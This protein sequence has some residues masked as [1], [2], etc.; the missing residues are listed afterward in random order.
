MATS[1]TGLR[2][3]DTY[4]AI[5]KIGDNSN[6]S[7]T[8]KLLSDGVGNDT[9]LYLSGTRLGIGITPA[10]QFHTSGNAKIGGNLIISGNLT[11]NGTLTYLNVTDLQVEDP[12]IKLAK[13]N[14]SNTLDIGF[15][16]KYVESATTKY[17]GLFWDASTDK[18]RLYEGLQVEPTTT[19]DVTG[20]GYT[21]SLLNA[22][23]EGN[24]TGTVSS[25]SNHDTND[26]VEGSVNLYFT[27]AR[28]RASFT[29]GTGVTI[30]NG[31][32]AIGQ[33]VGTTSNV[34]FGN[35]TGSAISGTTGTFSGNINIEST[36][37]RINLTDT[38]NND[39][40]SIFNNNGTYTVFN[41]TDAVSAFY[42][43]SSNNA[44][45]AGNVDINGNLQ[46][47]G[48][49][50][51]SSGDAGTSG[52]LLSST[53]TGTNWIDFE[54]DVAKRIDVTV[55]NVSGASLAKGVVVHAA[56]TATPPSGNV[57]EVIAADANVASSMPAIGILNETIA[58]EAE[59][60]AVM[61][62]AVSG[63]DTSGFSIGDE[64]YVSETVGL[65]T[66]TKPTAFGSQVQKIA[67]VIKSHASNGLIKV[68]GAGRANDVP[69]RVDRDMNFTD[70]SELT[71]GDS[72]DLKIYHTT[73]NIVRINSG[74]LIFNSFVDD[75]DIKF[76]LDNG[77][78]P[79]SLT[80]YMR[81][82]GGL[83][84]T[85]FSK[86]TIYT[87]NTKALF[88]SSS[89]LSIDCDG[90]NGQIL[91]NTG[92][93]YITNSANDKSIIFQSDNGIGGV[94]DYFKIDGNINR[95]VIIVTTQLN[96][97]VPMIFGSGAG[98]PSIKYDTTATQLFI[99]GESKF[100][101]DLYVV[102]T[103]TST[104]DGITLQM[105]GGSSAEGIRLQA[106]SSTTY[107]VFLRSISP[108]SGESSPWI[109][110]ENVTS[111]GIWHNNPVNSFDFT[112]SG[113][114][115]GAIATNVGG[116]TNSVMIRLN[117]TDGS[118]TFVGNIS[119]PEIDLP[120]GG[121]VDWANGDAR[122]VEGLV[123]NYSLSFQTYDGTN[124]STALR[125]DGNNTA[126]FANNAFITS[127]ANA[128]TDTDKFLVSDSGEIKYRTG[129]EVASDISATLDGQYV[130]YNNTTQSTTSKIT[131]KL[132]NTLTT[133]YNEM[134]LLNDNNDTIVVGS[135]G[136]G[137]TS[138][139]W[140]G[141]TYV[142][143]TGT[144]RKMYIKSQ[145][146]LRFLS[147]GTSITANTALVLDTSQNAIVGGTSVGQAGSVSL[148]KN[149]FIS[150]VLAS[151]SADS[152]LINAIY[153]V[154]NGFQLINDANNNQSYIF[155]NGTTASLKIDTNGHVGIGDTS[156]D[157]RLTVA[158]TSIAAPAF[159]VSGAY[160]GGPRIQ[161]Y[162]LDI[163]ANAWMG[164]GTDMSGGAYEHNIYFSDTG[165][166]GR[167]SMGTY[168]GTTYSEKMC[169]LRTG[170]V[171]ISTEDPLHNLQIGT[172]AT[173]G[174]Y[175]MMIE[176][177]FGDTALSSNPRLNLIDTNF[178]I[179]A[180]KYGSGTSN[181]A[182]GIF[183]Y[184]GTGR[185]IVFAHTT[186]GA[187]T[188]LSN[189]RQDMFIDGGTGRVGIN[190]VT[191]SAQLDVYQGNIRRSGIDSGSYL[192][193]GD[194]PG[195]SANAFASL[196]SGGTLHFSNNGKYCAYLEGA[197]TYF[198][199]LNSST[200]TKVF[201]NTSGSSYLT[202]GN[203]GV[204]V[205]TP[206]T[207][208]AVYETGDVWHTKIGNDS[209]Q[210]RIGG[211]TGSGAVIQSRNNSGTVRDLYLQRDGGYVGIGVASTPYKFTVAD[212]R[213]TWMARF[214]NVSNEDVAVFISHGDGYGMAIDS[215]ENDS[216]YILKCAGGTGGGNGRG[217]QIRLLVQSNGLIGAGTS[218]PLRLFDARGLAMFNGVTTSNG[219]SYIYDGYVDASSAYLHQ[220]TVMIR[221]DSTKT[222]GIDEAP[223]SLAIFNISGGDNTMT[224]LSF[225]SRETAGSGNTVTVAGIVA[226]KTAGV[227]GSWASGELSLFTKTGSSY[228]EGMVMDSAGRSIFNNTTKHTK[229]IRLNRQGTA[230]TGISWYNDSYYNWQN[231]M[232]SAGTGNCGP[233]ANLTAP[234]GLSSVTS[235]A[236]RSRMEGIGTYG[237]IWETGG[238]GGGGAT[239]SA[240]MELGATNGTLRVTGDLV[241]YASDERLKTNV[242]NIS[243]P[244]EKIKQIN[245]VE[246]DWVD[247]IQEKYDFHPNNMHEVG[248]LAQ[249]IKKVLPEA[250]LTAPM[251]APYKE[252]TGEDHNFLT[253][254]YE[255]IVPLLIE[256]IK[257]LTA[258]VEALENKCK[259]K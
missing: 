100:L 34:T 156:P 199:I 123:N 11:V 63:I 185:G 200:Q 173:N 107:P 120:S 41:S 206:D 79:S 98:S 147:G 2:V 33:A 46:V 251:N 259:C 42:I 12:L 183:A 136:S 226:R 29:A 73:N 166:L 27:T 60:E 54:A 108:A 142:Y 86:P 88:G 90:T 196:T 4:N 69:N 218:S 170:K 194:L 82:D 109:Y 127:I 162:G 36:L 221:T 89:L 242:K 67:V 137:Y 190:T 43:N 53:G 139:D 78:D 187:T 134:R 214:E 167:L 5:I 93:L 94:T 140:T 132:K 203:F 225:A 35:I 71:F 232:A 250:V 228:S 204:G 44:T 26:L 186:A 230:S 237:W 234:S 7:A 252:K 111:W 213:T 126:T 177:N 32:I 81:L 243:N 130:K 112:R 21:R 158:K 253:V 212:A 165:S 240:K 146:E 161:T 121:M 143:N 138:A 56:P 75:G 106:D 179:T 101:N 238:T 244:I 97:N 28:A 152:T 83:V 198:G 19:V 180:G 122:I 84:S 6:L 209:G 3:Q 182:L 70:D 103:I 181:D 208:L 115:S 258:K 195:Y 164:L 30:T 175:S 20:T 201:L 76:Q 210:I 151:G 91:Q 197:N 40:W 188:S 31:E 55:K 47:D 222:G 14:T 65:L 255:R 202:G 15:F 163:D 58:D 85:V 229:G 231:Y 59:G 18:F 118:G 114:M 169:V 125:L 22:D 96:D 25:L 205:T 160:Y 13:D 124:V 159:M 215:S 148:K 217:S 37:P 68:F 17:T 171:G 224:K 95:N 110:K 219:G 189:M 233:N 157:Y 66:A 131:I 113:A 247:D 227:S 57:I 87:N 116:G 72:S 105:D 235:W 45:F 77:A 246:Y 39:D 119:T 133:G 1:Y 64:L 207:R 172:A 10:Y 191:P 144:G 176:G 155:H 249:E 52:Q 99:S 117:N 128:T 220:P 153:G 241:A 174:S 223:A 211:Q 248:V 145:D 24:V 154:S 192:E 239:A 254:K 62:G 92:D 129:A 49:I 8:P 102:E 193:I 16:G 48:T 51:D 216:K 168:N 141:A 236:L 23:L 135:I 80:E 104:K 184:Q 178:G 257:E 150:G 9:P 50:K 245:G 61:F 74:D 38:D 149:G 256:S